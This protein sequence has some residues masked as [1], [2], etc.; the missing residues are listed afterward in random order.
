MS[1]LNSPRRDSLVQW[2]LAGV[3]EERDIAQIF[4]Q[5]CT[6]LVDCGVELSRA[7]LHI[8]V[9]HPQW[10]G[11]RIIWARG[12]S[13]PDVQIVGYEV[14]ATATFLQSP[15]RVVFSTGSEIRQKL[16]IHGPHAFPLYEE[17][18][19]QGHSEYTG[20]PIDH[21]QGKRHLITFSTDRPNG[22]DDSDIIFLREILPVFSLV[23]EIRV[24]NQLARTLLETYVGPHASEQILDG[25]TT[26]GSGVSINA[27]IMICDLRGF[28]KLS[29]RR[30]RDEV[31]S[32][33]NQYFDAVAGPVDRHG[34]EILK[35][36][37]DG[38]LAIFPLEQPRACENLLQ[39]VYD[40]QEAIA[41]AQR[42]GLADELRYGTGVHVGEVMYG[43]IGSQKR[44][45]FTVIG[46]A[47]NLASRLEN[48]T[49][50]L[51]RPVL[52]SSEFVKLA[53]CSERT[54][55]MGLHNLRGF[56]EPVEV[57]ALRLPAHTF[58]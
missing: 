22:F 26:R 34:G 31:I 54:E 17:L 58:A 19:E 24:K 15:Y 46:P 47:V 7:S 13:R 6:R 40:A 9:Y 1:L 5:L 29:D 50:E 20:W 52:I 36:I 39:A 56:E 35:F 51:Q 33:L 14:V 3:R 2:L 27:A 12:Q 38:L 21:T 28:T 25:A 11:T 8:R 53:N 32:I 4:M 55:R 45:D 41:M 48:L 43:N 44:L 42:T 37:G 10:L 18:R 16:Q 23:S 30:P 49:K 57:H